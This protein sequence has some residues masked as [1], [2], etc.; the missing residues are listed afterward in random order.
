MKRIALIFQFFFLVCL[1]KGQNSAIDKLFDK[2]AGKDG[3]TT[4]TISKQ[5][6]ELFNQ[7][8]TNSKED[9]DFKDV[10]SKLTSIRILAMEKEG[11]NPSINFYKELEKDLPASQYKEL[12]VVKD[13]GQDVKFL[14]H[15]ENGKITELILISGG[16]DNALICITG[17][18]DLKTISKLSKSMQIHGMENLDQIKK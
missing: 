9:K 11:D 12:M 10:A 16:T 3:F 14:T 13:K 8:E 15:E 18:I 2:Y 1:A 7:V 4:V 5:M 17:E 6:F